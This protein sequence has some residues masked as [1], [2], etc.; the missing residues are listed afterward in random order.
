M[1]DEINPEEMK[2]VEELKK[3]VMKKILTKEAI[4]RL[5]RI[6]LVKADLANQ[7]ELYLVQL[8]QTG[9]IKGQV[10]DEQLKFILEGL[11]EKKKFNIIR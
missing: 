11:T 1:S 8:Y 10:T 2:K 7:L 3:V 9:K 4:E 6:R 5:G